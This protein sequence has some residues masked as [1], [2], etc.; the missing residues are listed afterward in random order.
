[1]FLDIIGE[2]TN[3]GEDTKNPPCCRIYVCRSGEID[4]IY[5]SS[6][7]TGQGFVIKTVFFIY[8][9]IIRENNY[10]TQKKKKY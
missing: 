7:V 6:E 8:D 10:F 2:A 9:S 1:M 4:R 3:H 5:V